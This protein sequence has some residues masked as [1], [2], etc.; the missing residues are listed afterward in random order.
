M[1]SHGCDPSGECLEASSNIRGEYRHP[2]IGE[3]LVD[4][5]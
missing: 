1:G 4:V 3:G 5:L 2:W